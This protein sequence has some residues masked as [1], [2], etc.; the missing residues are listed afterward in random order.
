M[1]TL[2]RSKLA[3]WQWTLIVMAGCG[4]ALCVLSQ[5]VFEMSG[6]VVAR[7]QPAAT[8]AKLMQIKTALSGYQGTSGSFPTT[9]DGL[10]A[11][12]VGM[13]KEL[14]AVPKDG[15]GSAFIYAMPPA[16]QDSSRPFTLRSAGPDR[17]AFTADDIDAWTL[18]Y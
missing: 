5:I 14:E 17:I 11:L 13:T 6:A 3:P 7:N 16:P 10:V 18:N 12:T 2:K 15:W 1:G 4:L 8:R 9:K